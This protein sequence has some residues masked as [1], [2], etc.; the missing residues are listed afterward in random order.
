MREWEY[1]TRSKLEI[2]AGYLP[3]FNL[4]CQRWPDRLYID[5]MAGSP[6]NR[7]RS[8]GVEFDG[9]ARLALTAQPPFTRLAFCEKADKAAEL[10]QDLRP[11]H[12]RRSFRIYAGDCNLTIDQV[13]RDLS[14]WRRCPTF[15]FADQQAA[16]VHWETLRKL[17]AFRTGGSKAELW[18]LM[19][20]AMIVRGVAG[21]EA[22]AFAARV[23]ALYGNDT[24][25]RIQNARRNTRLSGEEYRDEMVNLLR[26]QL[27]QELGYSMTARIPMH[28]T[29]GV[30]IYDLVFATDNAVGNKIM[31][32]LYR[33]A[34]EREPRMIQQAK[35]RA[36]RQ[37]EEKVGKLTL[38]DM[39]PEFRIDAIEW[40]PSPSWD[41][42]AQPWW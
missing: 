36:V 10:E 19:S 21:T 25:H 11:Q 14:P 1:W 8:T 33:K 13:L 15:V 18:I 4:A 20:P 17:A 3:A 38:F 31:T 7:E 27:E 16:E 22:A 35:A 9:S 24:W 42:T 26:W 2:L 23:N 5:L 28:M 37:R 30:A 34:A 41:P 6:A 32:H 39:E 29:N 12:P 40:E